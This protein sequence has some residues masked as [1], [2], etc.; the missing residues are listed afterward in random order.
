VDKTLLK[1][2]MLASFK[3]LMLTVMARTVVQ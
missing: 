3:C 1:T 2:A